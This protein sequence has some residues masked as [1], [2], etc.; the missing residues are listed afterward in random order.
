MSLDNGAGKGRHEAKFN[1]V[2]DA[3]LTPLGKKQAA[4][5]APQIKE[6]AKEV[7]LVVSSPLKRTLQT[8]KLGWAPALERLGIENVICLPQA[9]ECNARTP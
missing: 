2:A 1:V 4:T 8:T 5:L 9:Q 6:L 7:D 3:P